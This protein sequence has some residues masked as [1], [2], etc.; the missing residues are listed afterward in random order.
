MNGLAVILLIGIIFLGVLL[1]LK[2]RPT[3]PHIIYVHT[4]APE[5]MG[6]GMGCLSSVIF[7]ILVLIVL[8]LF[9]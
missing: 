1:V 5:N 9:T 6:G 2:P 3:H 4:E 8:R 7:V